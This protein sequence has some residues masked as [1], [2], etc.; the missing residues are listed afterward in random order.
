VPISMFKKMIRRQLRKAGLEIVPNSLLSQLKSEASLSQ[1]AASLGMMGD[2]EL[3]KTLDVISQSPSQLNQDFFV[4][5]ELDWKY[6]GYFVEF[7]A[8]DGFTLNNT[9]LLEKEFGWSGI[10]A[11]PSRSWREA[12]ESS[13]RSARIELDCV[14]STSNERLTFQEA[15][16]GELSTIQSFGAGD[17]HD[18]QGSTAYEVQTV[19]LGDLLDRHDAPAVVDYLSIDTEGSEY[20]ILAAFDFGKRKFRCITCEHNFTDKREAI[21]E[22][23]VANGYVRKFTEISRFDDWYVLA[24]D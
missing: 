8:T 21:H 16:W 4:L 13:G 22:L 11:E 15:L 10:L 18:R 2:H 6:G 1:K 12:L 23:L 24:D 3:R 9:W 7:G 5:H 19:S 17:Q 14:W 20:E